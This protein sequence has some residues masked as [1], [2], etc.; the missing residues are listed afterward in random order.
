MASCAISLDLFSTKYQQG[1]WPKKGFIFGLQESIGMG[2]SKKDRI[3]I[4]WMAKKNCRPATPLK[5]SMDDLGVP[6][7]LS[8][9]RWDFW[10]CG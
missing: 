4:S 8:G 6:L 10:P 9:R 3:P 1:A 2:G 5:K 7:Y